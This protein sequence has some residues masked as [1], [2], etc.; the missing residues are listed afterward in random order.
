MLLEGSHVKKRHLVVLGCCLSFTAFAGTMGQA[1]AVVVDMHPWSVVGSIGYTAYQN[2]YNSNGQ[3]PVG[4]LAIAKDLFNLGDTGIGNDLFNAAGTHIGLEL[5]VQNGNRMPISVP[6]ATLDT[7]G[8]LPI[9]TTVKPMLDLLATVQVAPM[10]ETPAFLVVK[11]G[12]AYRQWQMDRDTVNNLSE[13]AGEVQAG[14]GIPVSDAATLSLLYQGV[15]GS[16]PHFTVNTTAA[17]GHVS[18]IPVQNGVLLS[19]SM[20]L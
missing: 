9:S 2:S 18:N 8:G 3:T 13:V 1:P 5:G 4:R 7:L 19:L 15:Y 6:Q 11:G 14:V 20:T 17:T 12:I 16:S 10:A